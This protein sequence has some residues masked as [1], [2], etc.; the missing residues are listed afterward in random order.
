MAARNALAEVRQQAAGLEGED[1]A[2]LA[3][4]LGA[5]DALLAPVLGERANAWAA[6][7]ARRG[8]D[9]DNA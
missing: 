7:L 2:R 9:D 1:A 6:L 3:H 5:L 8:G 4:A